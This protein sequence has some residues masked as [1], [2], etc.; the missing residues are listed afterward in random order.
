MGFLEHI[1]VTPSHHRVHHAINK[2]YMDKNL[3]QIFIF[4]DKLF[5]TFQQ[6]LDDVKPVYGVTRPVKTW[7]PVKINFI[8]LW[9]LIKDAWRTKS[10]KDKFRIW[11][12]P[13]GWRPEDVKE[14][15]PVDYIA[16]PYNQKKFDT[17]ASKTFI[18]WSW[19][20]MFF[21]YF[22]LIYFFAFIAQIDKPHI[23]YYGA[24]VFISIYAYT[25]LM[26]GNRYAF[27][28]EL[29]K[30]LIGLYIIYYY[31]DWFYSSQHWPWY[32]YIVASYLIVSVFVTA[33]FAFYE[34][35]KSDQ[36]VSLA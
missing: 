3:S 18:A 13:T 10:I 30:S 17:P 32:H 19:S 2:E 11:F 20:Q 34:M 15:Y 35:K 9:L 29:I 31:G 27:Y 14:K 5:G 7:N 12:M 6:E 24:F 33:Y 1:L 23:F 26:D 8:H 28:M 36:Q 22:L 4:W 21:N 25:E 16:D